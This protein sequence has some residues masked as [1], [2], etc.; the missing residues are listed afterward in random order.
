MDFRSLLSFG[1]IL[2]DSLQVLQVG[3][4]VGTEY[5]SQ[6][7]PRWIGEKLQARCYSVENE[8]SLLLRNGMQQEL[9]DGVMETA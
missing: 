6:G 1:T 4:V 9:R 2:S 3:L 5:T 7:T 8:V